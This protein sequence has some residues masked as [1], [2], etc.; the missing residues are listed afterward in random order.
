M[1]TFEPPYKAYMALAALK[2]VEGLFKSVSSSP[3]RKYVGV[4]K[5]FLSVVQP[6]LHVAC[7]GI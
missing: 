1:G 6:G 7:T 5:I 2:A 3:T 4:L